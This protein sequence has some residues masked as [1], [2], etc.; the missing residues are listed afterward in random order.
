MDCDYYLGNG[1]RNPN[2]LWAGNEKEQIATM[3]D[4]WH[5]FPEEDTPEWLTLDDLA[6]YHKALNYHA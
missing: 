1:G 4:L 6:K 3:L 5:S 2:C